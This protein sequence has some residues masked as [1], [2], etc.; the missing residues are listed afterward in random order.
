M[1]PKEENNW[2]NLVMK[3]GLK[4]LRILQDIK[5]ILFIDRNREKLLLEEQL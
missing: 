4:W 1:K 5:T 3:I 2:I